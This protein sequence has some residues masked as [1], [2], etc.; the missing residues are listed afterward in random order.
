MIPPSFFFISRLCDRLRVCE[1]TMQKGYSIR[2]FMGHSSMVTS[3]DF[4]PN[5]D[6][7]I[8]SCDTD[9]EIRYWSINNGSYTRVYKVHL[10]C[11][12]STSCFYQQIGTF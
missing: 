3:L 6:D 8:C 9:G 1:S 7:L 12:F 4:H 5:K 2:T 11:L 10:F